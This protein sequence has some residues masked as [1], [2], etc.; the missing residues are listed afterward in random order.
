VDILIALIQNV[1]LILALTFIFHLASTQSAIQRIMQNPVIQG[2]LFGLFGVLSIMNSIL[3]MPGYFIDAR[4]IIVAVTGLFLGRLPM[5]IAAVMMSAVRVV[6][7]GTG[8]LPTIVNLLIV[9]VLIIWLHD[10]RQRKTLP[11]THSVLLGIGVGI[12]LMAN[13]WTM[14]LRG[15]EGI[16][17]VRITFVPTLLLYPVGMALIGMLFLNEEY[18]TQLEER[19]RDSEERFRTVVDNMN[20]GV[21][22]FDHKGRVVIV[23]PSA[24]HILGLSREQLNGQTAIDHNWRTIREDGS[25]F[26]GEEYPISVVLQTRVAQKNVVMGVYHPKDG[27]IWIKVNADPVML[28]GSFAVLVTFTDISEL[29]R[30]QEE[31]KRER[32]LMRTVIDTSPDAILLK[33]TEGKVIFSNRAHIDIAAPPDETMVGKTGFDLFSKETA[34][35]IRRDDQSVVTSGKSLFNVE[36]TIINP[37][38]E[39]RIVLT[40]KI[41][42]HAPNGNIVGLLA[43]IRDITE[44]KELETKAMELKSEQQRILAM[45]AFINDFS[46]DF[47]T[48]LS[49]IRSET[50]L[51]RKTNDEHKREKYLSAIEKQSDR[52]LHYLDDFL[53]MTRLDM[54]D[55]ASK[56]ERI[57]ANTI[58]QAIIHDVAPEF[59]EKGL[60]L[61]YQLDT[62]ALPVQINSVH[63]G[64]AVLNLVQNAINYTPSGGSISVQTARVDEQMI[65]TIRDSGIGISESDLPRVFERFYR[66]DKARSAST[67]G[68]G[69]GLS[70]ARKIIEG[71]Q[72]SIHIDSQVGVGTTVRVTIPLAHAA[73]T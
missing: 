44:L 13:F 26:P 64:R 30:T 73:T 2:L 27:L 24:A 12:A 5:L 23:N 7:G 14:V 42:W 40:T 52:L 19:L 67:G 57:D 49:I 66:A 20:D 65:L 6:I 16:E 50:Y 35:M 25:N 10:Y 58:V 4:Y 22:L 8:T 71:H 29:R 70:I 69:L 53:E 3:T 1:S 51:L 31:L 46:H 36:Q 60:Q 45:Q 41:P 55:F 72:G 32:D 9:S 28:G 62:E 17:I 47:R 56:T 21:V 54:E 11:L 33:D 63:F 34:E 38:N 18:Q 43:I 48:P 15:Q 59:Y 68:T 37:K 61:T 39:K